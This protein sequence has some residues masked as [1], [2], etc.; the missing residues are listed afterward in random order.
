[1]TAQEYAKKH[2]KLETGKKTI[3]RCIECQNEQIGYNKIDGFSC[4]KCG[5][6]ITPMRYV[7]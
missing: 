4:E 5:G 6:C 2:P 7:R 1:M 3:F